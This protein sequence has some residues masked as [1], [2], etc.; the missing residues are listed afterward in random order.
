MTERTEPTAEYRCPGEEYPISRAV[1]LGRL[2]RFYPGCR[3]CLHRD[4]T[5]TLS[6]RQVRQLLETRPRGLPRPLFDDEGA[7]GVYLNDLTPRIARDMAAALGVALQ[8][9]GGLGATAGSSSSAG[10]TVGQAGHRPKVGRGTA[11]Y[12]FDGSPALKG[13]VPFSLRENRDSPQENR[14]S[15]PAEPVVVIAGDGRPMS[16]ELV[17]AVG[18]GL[19]WAGCR[20]VDIGPATAA[21]LT[22]AIDHL[23]ASGGILVGNP[24]EKP[25][26]VGLKFWAGPRPLS[27]GG[28][29][30]ALQQM[31][32]AGV[33]RPT[34]RYGP[35]RRFQAELPYLAGLAGYYHALRP[36]RFVLESSCGPL[37]EYSK[38]LTG[39][40][41]CRII[42]CRSANA[43]ERLSERIVA[44]GAHFGVAVGSDGETCRL[45]DEQG[46]RVPAERLLLLVAG[47]LL[48]DC[49][50]FRA[51]DC[52]DFRAAKMGL[53]P[54]SA[55]RTLVLEE[56]TT[57]EVADTIRAAGGRV[58]LSG[59]RRAEM[60][61]AM[62]AHGGLLGGGPSG[63]LWYDSDGLPL[64]DALR[65]LTLLLVLLS[66]S[67]RPLSEVLDCRA[68]LG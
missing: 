57:T 55:Q 27:A 5:A 7:G 63:R 33:D 44:E 10:G 16:C 2:A 62:R 38:K 34:R 67:D 14:D 26:M 40:V 64:P 15:P 54:S 8:R 29:L 39:S 46:R 1:H 28:T 25:Q 53:S 41:A 50:D 65:T 30:D 23:A 47:H 21:C 58:A 20:V 56:G 24:G 36:L 4:D 52:P 48:G 31:Y 60:A 9:R 37:V 19:R 17:A 49:P 18:E 68:P 45:Y 12:E 66:Q 59:A 3:Q 32:Q 35:L 6:E 42:E 43:P 22:F 61:A 51:G 13:T 11:Q